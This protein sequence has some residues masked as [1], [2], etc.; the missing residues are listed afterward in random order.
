MSRQLNRLSLVF[1]LA[2]ALVI[3]A[4]GY[5]GLVQ[6]GT[7]TARG[8]NP[9]RILLERRIPRGAILD[10]NGLV[11]AETTGPPGEYVR[12]YPYPALSSLLGY[13]SPLYGTAGVEA[14]FD[15]ILH[16]DAGYD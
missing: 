16:G 15:P 10:R 3:A 9:R 12:H 5:W 13:I 14:A 8:D 2:F 7:L 4:T 6:A 11:L 1:G